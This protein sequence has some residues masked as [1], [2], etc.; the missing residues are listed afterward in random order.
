MKRDIQNFVE[1]GEKILKMHE[2][3]DLTVGEFYQFFD[4]FKQI[5]SEKGTFDAIFVAIQDAFRLG[6]AVGAGCENRRK[7]R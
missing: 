6:V 2:R 5:E 4:N 7:T 3:C 1:R